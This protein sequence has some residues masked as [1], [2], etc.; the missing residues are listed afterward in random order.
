[1]CYNYRTRRGQALLE[2]VLAS[3][4]LLVVVALLF[5]LVRVAFDYSARTERLTVMDCP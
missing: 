2:Y 4:G 1:M 5:G 3:A